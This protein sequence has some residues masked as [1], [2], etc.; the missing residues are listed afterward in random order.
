[1]NNQFLLSKLFLTC[2]AFLAASAQANIS[3]TCRYEGTSGSFAT[4]G[5]VTDYSYNEATFNLTGV[6]DCNFSYSYPAEIG[7]NGNYATTTFSASHSIV[8]NGDSYVIEASGDSSSSVFITAPPSGSPVQESNAHASAVSYNRI[9][10]KSTGP[11]EYSFITSANGLGYSRHDGIQLD[12]NPQQY[13]HHSWFVGDKIGQQ[14][15]AHGYGHEVGNEYSVTGIVLP[16]APGGA[17]TELPFVYLDIFD[18]TS[19]G[20][21]LGHPNGSP[22][23]PFMNGAN[24]SYRLVVTPVPE[25]ATHLMFLFGG[26]AIIAWTRK[27]K[28]AKSL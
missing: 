12:I 2:I 26:I 25:P 19:S 17:S 15:V 11:I 6:E 20:S 10:L 8:K 7:V 27:G 24:W 16:S 22:D 5:S 18:L 9:Q 13:P 28:R 1:M 14:G 3:L 4:Y 23:R 21:Q